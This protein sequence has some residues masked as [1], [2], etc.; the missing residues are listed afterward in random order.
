MVSEVSCTG[1][2]NPVMTVKVGAEV[3]GKIK[4]LHEDFNSEVVEGQLIARIDPE[5]F[6]ARVSQARAA[7]CII[8][9]SPIPQKIRCGIGNNLHT[10]ARNHNSIMSPDF[11]GSYGKYWSISR[12]P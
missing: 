7:L 8:G 4:E 10:I 5:P 6:E 1:T 9:A 3:T 2:V 12:A 11:D